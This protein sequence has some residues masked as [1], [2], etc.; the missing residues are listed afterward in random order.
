MGLFSFF[1]TVNLRAKSSATME[2]LFASVQESFYN[3]EL[4]YNRMVKALI[5]VIND[6]AFENFPDIFNGKFGHRP[7]YLLL[8][9]VGMTVVLSRSRKENN[10][11]FL[12]I[13]ICASIIHDGLFKNLSF[14]PYKNIDREVYNLIDFDFRLIVTQWERFSNSTI[15]VEIEK[16]EKSMQKHMEKKNGIF[17]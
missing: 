12:P 13:L 4:D 6:A 11:M 10:P 8:I 14:P 2:F 5:N 7:D 16:I 15:G 9:L 3:S 1:G 17:K